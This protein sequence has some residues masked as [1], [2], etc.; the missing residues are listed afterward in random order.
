MTRCW[1]TGRPACMPAR[2]ASVP[3]TREPS[4]PGRGRCRSAS[5]AR[6]RCS[7]RRVR[8]TPERFAARLAEAVSPRSGVGHDADFY[9][10]DDSRWR[11]A[12]PRTIRVLPGLTLGS[13]HRGRAQRIAR[14]L[15]EL[16]DPEVGRK[17]LSGRF[18]GHDFSHLPPRSVA[19]AG[20]FP[21]SRHGAGG[22]QPDRGDHRAGAAGEADLAGSCWAT[23]PA[24]AGIS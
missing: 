13:A 11:G 20:G 12:A 23:W 9:P 14:E 22:A 15:N 1:M 19:L 6:P 10:P 4:P 16:S 17:R 18:G 5:P 8:R 2:A 3:S 24:R 7:Y 21:R